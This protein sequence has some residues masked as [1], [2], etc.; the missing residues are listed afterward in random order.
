MTVPTFS[1]ETPDILEKLDRAVARGLEANARHLLEFL[2][3]GT[4]EL[5]ILGYP[6]KYAPNRFAHPTSIDDAVRLLKLADGAGPTGCYVIANSPDPAVTTRM[7]RDTWHPSPKGVS[8]KDAEILCRRVL[9]VDVDAKRITGTSATEAEFAHARAAG[10]KVYD[11]LATLV[12]ENALAF[13][14]SGNGISVLVALANIPETQELHEIVR[15]MIAAVA[16]RF[17]HEPGIEIDTTVTD[18]K[19]LIPAF[20]TTKRKGSRMV[21]ERPH[22]ATGIVVP[23]PRHLERV[24]L[25]GLKN[26]LGALYEEA[27]DIGR[28]RID[29]AMGKKAPIMPRPAPAQHAQPARGRARDEGPDPF[30]AAKQVPVRDVLAWLGL[31]AGDQPTCPGCGL[32][33]KGVAVVKNGLKC[34]HNRCAE[35]G[36]PGLAGWRT[37]IDCV[38]E[39]KDVSPIQAV[40]LMGEHFG[41]EVPAPDK[42]KTK[43]TKAPPRAVLE[44]PDWYAHLATTNRGEIVRSVGN[45]ITVLTHDAGWDGVLVYDQLAQ[46]IKAVKA[47]PWDAVDCVKPEAGDWSDVDTIRLVSWLGRHHGLHIG[48]DTAHAAVEVTAR[49][50]T[51]DPIVDYLAALRWDGTRRVTSWLATYFGSADTEY[52]RLVGR[53]FLVAAV[54]RAR[55]PGCKVDTM[56]ILEGDQGIKKSSGTAALFGTDWTSHSPPDLQSKDRFTDLRGK[57]CI[58][59]GELDGLARGDVDRLKGFMSSP[60]DD[61][62]A[63][64]ARS[65]SRIPRRSVFVGTVN[66]Q[67]Y[68]R[69][70]TGNRRFWPVWCTKVAFDELTRDRDQ[71]WAEAVALFESDPRW[72]PT[73]Q[74]VDLFKASQAERMITDAWTDP[75][76]AYLAKPIT[77]DWVTVAEVLQDALKIDAG[78][79]TQADQQRVGRC[80]VML[81]WKRM[82]RQNLGVRQWG[83]VPSCAETPRAPLRL[84]CTRLL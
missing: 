56:L 55:R 7:S 69:D 80:L 81:G 2:G 40:R 6:D 78:R 3:E 15:G 37:T 28:A 16:H 17:E 59:W 76:A 21:E 49:Q 60:V 18:A 5:Q 51:I 50:R 48:L 54:A 14:H 83:Y 64:Y 38:V 11:Y 34:S 43:G 75:I 46:A 61:Y 19:R 22:R 57:W 30:A 42:A 24:G 10:S 35:R 82:Q 13:G 36:A 12:G 68:L 44:G 63:P 39:A 32:D 72:W 45:A 9:F 20:G 52:T 1:S 62:R 73:D 77:G 8:T 47:P 27:D 29:K 41:F 71:L 53:F 65:S 33:D 79:W 58:E 74:E 70:E 23:E 4:T 31:L 67:S 84:E 26:V 66:G 25:A